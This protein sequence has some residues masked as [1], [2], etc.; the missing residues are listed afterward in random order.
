MSKPTDKPASDR[1]PEQNQPA[2]DIDPAWLDELR[3]RVRLLDEGKLNTVPADE[4]IQRAR[5]RLAKLHK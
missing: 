4:A 3:R 1:E 5:E 2:A